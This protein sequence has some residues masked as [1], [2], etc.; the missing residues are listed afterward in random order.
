MNWHG[1]GPGA[2]EPGVRR[3]VLTGGPAAGKTVT[4]DVLRLEYTD[5]VAV[6]PE[7]ASILYNGGFPRGRA[8][9]EHQLVQEAIYEVQ[10]RLERIYAMH[11]PGLPHICDRGALDGAAYWP[12]GLEPF[13]EAMETD[14]E[15]EYG[16]YEQVIFLE[17]SAWL[18]DAYTTEGSCRNETPAEARKLDEILR[19]IWE[20]HPNLHV[21]RHEAHFSEK[22]PQ[23][24]RIIESVTGARRD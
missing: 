19:Q 9:Q 21:I 1:S 24:L 22:I 20:Q 5:S 18:E 7:S 17:T 8:P 15:R 23:V 6:L 4:A 2:G 10:G 11:H 13:L 14:I 3:I 12:G 16:R